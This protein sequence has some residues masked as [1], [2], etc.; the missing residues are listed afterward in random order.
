MIKLPDASV[1]GSST[2]IRENSHQIEITIPVHGFYR[3]ECVDCGDLNSALILHD[4]TLDPEAVIQRHIVN[5]PLRWPEGL[6]WNKTGLWAVVMLLAGSEG[7]GWTIY[8]S[9]AVSRWES[10][11]HAARYAGQRA[12]GGKVRTVVLDWGDDLEDAGSDRLL[13]NPRVRAALRLTSM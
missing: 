13:S 7:N 1:A 11:E 3:V 12:T 5:R 6:D 9:A 8:P 10:Q 4:G 2:I